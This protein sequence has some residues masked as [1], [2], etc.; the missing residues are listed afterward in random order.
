AAGVQRVFAIVELLRAVAAFMIAPILL[1]AA[2]TV[3]SS[4]SSGTTIALWIAF[5]L[6]AGGAVAGVGLYALGRVHPPIP[7]FER[8]LAGEGTAW[9]SPPLLARIRRPP[10]EA[11]PPERAADEDVHSRRLLRALSATCRPPPARQLPAPDAVS[12]S[13]TGQPS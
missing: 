9:E 3:G 1:H 7:A 5:G 2:L 10:I 6:S 8:W 13:G 12:A 4:P 11:R